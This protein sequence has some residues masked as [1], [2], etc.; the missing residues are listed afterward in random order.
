[1]KIKAFTSDLHVQHRNIISYSNRPFKDVEEMEETLIANYNKVIGPDEL[2]VILGDVFFCGKPK[3]R[4]IMD[5]LNGEKWLVKGNHDMKTNALLDIGFSLVVEQMSIY[6]A[7]Q[8]VKLCHFPYKD[9]YH[10]IHK[11]GDDR[12]LDKRPKENINQWL[13]HGHTHSTEQIDTKRKQ[14]HVGVDAWNYEPVLYTKIEELIKS[15]V[16]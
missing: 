8:Q 10:G 5:R 12:Y 9:T 1:M 2:C 7:G 4:S 11:D 15:N 6:I 16:K 14:L 13:L 3:A